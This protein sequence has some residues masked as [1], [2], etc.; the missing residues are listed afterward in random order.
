MTTTP[1]QLITKALHLPKQGVANTIKL[2]DE[3]ATIPFIA[4]YRKEMTGS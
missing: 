4:R 1:I 2:L 3:G